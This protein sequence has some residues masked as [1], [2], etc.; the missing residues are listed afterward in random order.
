MDFITHLPT[1]ADS[2]NDSD[3]VVVDRSSKMVHF[4]PCKSTVTAKETADMF[5]REIFRLHGL[6]KTIISDRDKLFTS[7]FWEETFDKLRTKLLKSSG[8]HPQTDGQTERMNPT[9]EEMLGAYCGAEN[10]QQDWEY[11]LP[12]AEIQYNTAS[13]AT[14]KSPI[15]LNYGQHP[16]TPVTLFTGEEP[17]TMSVNADCESFIKK[18]QKALRESTESMERAQ[19]RAKEYYDQGKRHHPFKVGDYVFVDNFALPEE[20]RGSKISPLRHG[21]FKITKQINP[22]AF[23][24][25][26]PATW[27]V[28]NVFHVSFLTPYYPHR[29]LVPER[30]LDTRIYKRKKQ[31]YVRHENAASHQDAWVDELWLRDKHPR[32]YMEFLRRAALGL[33]H[34]SFEAVV[35]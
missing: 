8:Y 19:A 17:P 34:L 7:K 13:A 35:D 23:K 12:L 16:H 5:I 18:L 1:S 10:R 11:Y 14:G 30:V 25:D 20:R 26:T 32:V 9:L 31:L 2:G 27:R 29:Q 3:W 15:Y 24:L 22:V 33:F 21:P 4:V 28:H 6:P